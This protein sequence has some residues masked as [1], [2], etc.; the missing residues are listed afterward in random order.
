MRIGIDLGGSKTE[1]VILDNF[2]VE[3]GR[4]RVDTPSSDY[5]KIIGTLK[6][7]VVELEQPFGLPASIGVGTP[8]ATSPYSGLIKNANTTC[9]NGRP[10]QRDLT[11]ALGRPVKVANDAD[12]FILSESKDGAAAGASVAFGVILGTGVGGG[13]TVRG[14]LLGGPNAI[15]GEWGHNSLPFV[16]AEELPGEPCFCGKSGCIETFLSGPGMSTDHKKHTG[17][18]MSAEE[19]HQAASLGEGA[20]EATMMRYEDRLARALAS[21]INVLDPNVIVLGGG[22]SKMNRLYQRVPMLL[23]KYVFSDHV[24]TRV[25]AAKHGDA[26]GVLGAAFLNE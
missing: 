2:G 10:F 8:G 6:D 14:K 4:K 24:A 11:Q 26:S 5:D 18:S 12:C 16:R 7:L 23:S 19:I 21:V 13:V 22:L 15:A 9:L 25:V 1:A 17:Q 20:A 3:K